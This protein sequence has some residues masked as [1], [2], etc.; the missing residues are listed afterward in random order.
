MPTLRHTYNSGYWQTSRFRMDA[1]LWCGRVDSKDE[2][3]I[4]ATMSNIDGVIFTRNTHWAERKLTRLPIHHRAF[5][6]LHSY[7]RS[8]CSEW[9]Y[10]VATLRLIETNVS[11][12][13]DPPI[14]FSLFIP[15]CIN[16]PS[17]YRIPVRNLPRHIP[18]WKRSSRSIPTQTTTP[19]SQSSTTRFYSFLF[20]FNTP[21]IYPVYTVCM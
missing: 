2:S 12:P 10:S 14:D 7:I 21:R 17:N 5:F 19:Y 9:W 3:R 16:H 6:D 20:F 15:R 4:V 11:S 8:R 1:G 18:G 13:F